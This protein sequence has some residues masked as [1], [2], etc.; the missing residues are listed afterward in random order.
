MEN[1][2]KE[3]Q[4]RTM[5]EEATQGV[6]AK[7]STYQTKMEEETTEAEESASGSLDRLTDR[8]SKANEAAWRGIAQMS[9]SHTKAKA[10]ASQATIALANATQ[11]NIDATKAKAAGVDAG[12]LSP[13][14]AAVEA[15]SETL[16]V[17]MVQLKTT[18]EEH[19][20]Q[21]ERCQHALAGGMYAAR[22]LS[23]FLSED[24]GS[25][26]VDARE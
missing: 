20:V 17:A 14:R 19:H 21:R 7:G 11:A 26:E 9:P 2:Y 10:A 8:M 5:E 18:S 23:S 25:L 24:D 1:E 16:A 6:G 12:I 22:N 3:K 13:T 15:T 4:G